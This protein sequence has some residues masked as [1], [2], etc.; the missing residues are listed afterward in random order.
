MKRKRAA[1]LVV[2]VL[3]AIAL[4]FLYRETHTSSTLHPS[5]T[6]TPPIA[7]PAPTPTPAPPVPNAPP[8]PT[9]IPPTPAHPSTSIS[10]SV[11]YFGTYSY[12]GYVFDNAFKIT[13]E[14]YHKILKATGNANASD[15][16]DY[17][18]TYSGNTWTLNG[19]VQGGSTGYYA[20]LGLKRGSPY[21]GTYYTP[22]GPYTL[23]F[24][25]P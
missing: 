9:P 3:V 12:N 5:T 24:H 6:P 10:V 19:Q 14:D 2:A 17:K 23:T 1:F 15:L 18:F 11:S 8:A 21:F 4:F 25:A 7:P 16:K 22:G 13:T 20:T